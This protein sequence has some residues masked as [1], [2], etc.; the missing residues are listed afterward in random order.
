LHS[1]LTQAGWNPEQTE[2]E[3]LLAAKSASQVSYS[4]L[5]NH[6]NLAPE[7]TPYIIDVPENG[8]WL[9]QAKPADQTA[10]LVKRADYIRLGG[11]SLLVLI[12]ILLLRR[13]GVM[14]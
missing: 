1:M 8:Q 12:T 13:S 2:F 10:E 4:L 11:G 7:S 3:L 9:L 14:Q 6:E 5:G